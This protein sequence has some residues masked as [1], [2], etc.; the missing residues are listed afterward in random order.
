MRMSGMAYPSPA[1]FSALLL[2]RPLKD[3]VNEYIFSG[4][5]YGG[6]PFAFRRRPGTM[7]V[8]TG[9]VRQYLNIPTAEITVIGSGKVGFSLSP[10]NYP[11][12]FFEHSDLDVMIVDEGLFDE[13]WHCLI[14]WNYPRQAL[15]WKD[16][17]WARHRR[18]EIF[19]G[20]IVPTMIEFEPVV[21]LPQALRPLRDLKDRWFR[22]FQSLSRLV[23]HPELATRRVTGRLYRTW[24]HALMYHVD[25]LA[26][27]RDIVRSRD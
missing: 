22:A 10:D 9:H 17:V 18:D 8:L 24:K 1:E 26:K 14:G 5:P 23:D 11:R 7:G 6:T 15:A 20:W 16:Y 27:I 2:E 13:V 19:W 21:H 12:P 25:G 3:V 4:K